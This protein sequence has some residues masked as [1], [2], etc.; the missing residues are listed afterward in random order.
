MYY[1][2]VSYTSFLLKCVI[3]VDNRKRRLINIKELRTICRLKSEYKF[4][5]TKQY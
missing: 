1:D 5:R 3:L 4:I 2:F